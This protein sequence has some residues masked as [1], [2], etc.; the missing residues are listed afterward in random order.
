LIDEF[1][2]FLGGLGLAPGSHVAYLMDHRV[3]CLVA[4]FAIQ[5]AG[6]VVAPFNAGL[7]APEIRYQLGAAEVRTVIVSPAKV[8]QLPTDAGS[9]ELVLVLPSPDAS[10]DGGDGGLGATEAAPSRL[11]DAEVRTVRLGGGAGRQ[12]RDDRGADEPIALWFTSGTTGVPKAVLH[13][14]RAGVAA[15]TSWVEAV[16]L[17]ADTL[18]AL[19][20]FHIG[21]MSSVIP[22]LA[23]G[24]TVVVVPPFTIESYLALVDRHHPTYLTLPP[25]I[26]GL[27]DR[28]PSLL[29]RYDT[30]SVRKIMIGSAPI[31]PSLLRRSISRFPNA[32]WK[33]AWAQTEINSGGTVT[34]GS[35]LDRF[36]SI[37]WGV[38]CVEQLAILDEDGAELAPGEIGELCVRGS[39]TMLGYFRDPDATAHTMRGGWLH[40]G[41]VATRDEDGFVFLKGRQR[42]MIIRG[43]ENVYP[44]E[45]EAVLCSHPAVAEAA[46]VGISDTVMTEVPAAVVVV[47][48]GHHLD[49]QELAAFAAERLARYKRPVVID[50]VDELPRNTIGKVQKAELVRRMA[51]YAR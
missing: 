40:T 39:M 31:E 6:F 4:F 48:A 29:D 38:R 28:D 21:M 19:N 44:A 47:R 9:L 22:N 51:A 16:P 15:S 41:D 35:L 26:L 20:F 12:V 13:S 17:D 32:V 37:G 10:G 46:A 18:L 1:A 45:I 14:K 24:G 25:V 49:T 5:R 7:T 30:S 42:E 8:P 27:I 23:T 2:G 50:I 34:P 36:G 3:E 43:G 11:G 33:E